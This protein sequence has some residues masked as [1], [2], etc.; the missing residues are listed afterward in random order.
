MGPSTGQVWLAGSRSAFPAN[1]WS[2]F[3]IVVV[4]AFVAA[5]LR[6]SGRPQSIERVHFMDGPFEVE[7]RR[8]Q[9]LEVEFRGFEN[10]RECFRGTSKL[11]TLVDDLLQHAR[12]LVKIGKE[13]GET[14]E[15]LKRLSLSIER[16]E[17]RLPAVD[18]HLSP[19]GGRGRRSR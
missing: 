4:E 16:L 11:K 14:S 10:G 15:D 9:D 8:Q 18:P 7:L 12:Q 5:V 6:A 19:S 1:G 17:R 2:D 3:V 13:A